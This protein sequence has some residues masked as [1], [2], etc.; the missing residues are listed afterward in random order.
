MVSVPQRVMSTG[1]RPQ[2]WAY[3]T[4]VVCAFVFVGAAGLLPV[5]GVAGGLRH[6]AVALA[7]YCA[8]TALAGL[9]ARPPAAPLTAA[10][11]WLFYD[12]FVI[13]Q[14][15]E[16]AWDGG[17]DAYRVA[18]LATASLLGTVAARIG[19]AYGTAEDHE[20]GRRPCSQ[21][22]APAG[23]RCAGRADLTND[24]LAKPG[25]GNT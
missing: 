14:R 20:Q 17:I 1:D 6:P 9:R 19:H 4:P 10:V 22:R 15:G 5:L 3:S 12:G 7:A 2:P 8:L 23:G 11:C 16:L 24:A 18:L 13:H 25:P 21:A